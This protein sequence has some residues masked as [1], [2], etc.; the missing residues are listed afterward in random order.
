MS[1]PAAT[2]NWTPKRLAIVPLKNAPADGTWE[3][4][5]AALREQVRRQAGR[6]P[7]PS[8][9]IIDSQSAKTTEKGSRAA[10]L[11]ARS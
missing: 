2:A 6:D 9:A 8:A 5:T 1:A 4:I 10:T 7:T 11:G 3:H